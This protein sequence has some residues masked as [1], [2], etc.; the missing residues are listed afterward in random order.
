MKA[1][2]ILLV[3]DEPIIVRTLS[4]ALELTGLKV[5]VAQDGDRALALVE[6]KPS[7]DVVITDLTLEG[8]DGMEVLRRAKERDPET[9]VIVITGYAAE[10]SALDALRFGAEDY[11]AKPFDYS[12]LL[13]RVSRC[14][15][16]R[17]LAR[18]VRTYERL[19]GICRRCGRI[20]QGA[21][22]GLLP[23]DAAAGRPSPP[24]A[25]PGCR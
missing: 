12:E 22:A 21:E 13:L 3:D 7:F 10:S 11:L 16:R 19:L 8:A 23:E 5:T 6:G 25:C 9:G 1:R 17:E 24:E 20:S 18:K 4:K 15:E 14:L 2:R